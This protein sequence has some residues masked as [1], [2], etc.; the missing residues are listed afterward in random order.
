M[1]QAP[2]D[3]TDRAHCRYPAGR[4]A[5]LVRGGGN[6]THV[7]RWTHAAPPRSP[8]QPQSQPAPPG[9]ELRSATNRRRTLNL[10][11]RHLQRTRRR[12]PRRSRPNPS[13]RFLAPPAAAEAA[14]PPAAA[15]PVAPAAAPA[16]EAAAP[17]VAPPE[18]TE[19]AAPAVDAS[20]PATPAPSAARAETPAVPPPTPDAEAAAVVPTFE[21]ATVDSRT[22]ITG[23]AEPNAT[24]EVLTGRRRSRRPRPTTAGEWSG[25]GQR[26]AGRKPRSRRGAHDLAE[27]VDLRPLRPARRPS[28][29]RA[30]PEGCGGRPQR[31]SPEAAGPPP[32]ARSEAAPEPS[33]RPKSLPPSHA[34]GA[35]SEAGDT[36][37]GGAPGSGGNPRQRLRRRLLPRLAA[38]EPL[39]AAPVTEPCCHCTARRRRSIGRAGLLLLRHPQPQSHLPVLRRPA[40]RQSRRSRQH[41]RSPQ[42]RRS[43]R[44]SGRDR[45]TCGSPGDQR[46]IHPGRAP[47]RCSAAG[48]RFTAGRCRAS[49][50]Q[51]GPP[52]RPRRRL[53]S[54]RSRLN[55]RA[56]AQPSARCSAG[57]VAATPPV[58]AA[59]SAVQPPAAAPTAP[60]S[61]TRRAGR[62]RRRAQG[63]HCQ[64]SAP[65]AA[66]RRDHRH[67]A[68]RQS[69]ADRAQGLGQRLPLVGH[70]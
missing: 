58:A 11:R 64:A 43:R 69:V 6:R 12:L 66:E 26:P 14:A 8:A 41:L 34:R 39:T 42:S 17:P 44:L 5:H 48:R 67:Q 15:T 47:G 55:R 2:A 4:R 54:R 50:R 16:A 35:A 53:R 13:P 56:A 23:L 18:T 10:R 7:G 31:P 60:R 65:G 52:S 29:P 36:G 61:A 32:P 40:A 51:A 22:V 49:R 21:V 70:L 3:R 62:N 37:R 30:E 9:G 38:A 28:G 24:V 59:P 27:P 33:H 20:A 57:V 1:D 68:R 25:A 19:P 46:T 63:A 45:A